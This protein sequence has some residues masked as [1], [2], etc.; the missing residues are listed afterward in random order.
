MCY[1]DLI[2]AGV[3][4][5]HTSAQAWRDVFFYSI[6]NIVLGVRQLFCFHSI[7]ARY[8][9]TTRYPSLLDSTYMPSLDFSLKKALSKRSE[10]HG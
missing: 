8:I 2:L 10:S 3:R 9:Q 5:G 6:I 7:K 4:L 1:S